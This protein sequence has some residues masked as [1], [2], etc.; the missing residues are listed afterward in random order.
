MI[1]CKTDRFSL[2]FE[3]HPLVGDTMGS[4][5]GPSLLMLHGGGDASRKRF[6][7]IRKKLLDAGISSCAFD[8]AGSGE[9]GGNTCDTS[10][11]SRT[12][13][14]SHV[15]SAQR[16][17]PPLSILGASMGAYTAVRLLRLHPVSN[18]ILFVP[19]MYTREAYTQNFQSEFSN[20]IRKPCS[21]VNSDAWDILGHFTGRLFVLAA[22]NDRVIPDDVITRVME[23]AGN[24]RF[25]K[26]LTVPDS[27]HQILD[28]L[29]GTGSSFM[30]PVVKE[31]VRMIKQ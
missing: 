19:A 15:I 2:C 10:L 27:P 6:Y 31:M 7:S 12:R 29:E 16:L 21:W 22:E 1:T 8:F 9:S 4:S 18:L 25:K 23:A 17:S 26:L 13:Q 28:Y 14:A 3:G 11:E 20:I 24:V 30:T 5:A